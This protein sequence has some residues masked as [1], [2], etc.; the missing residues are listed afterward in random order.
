MS[1]ESSPIVANN[2]RQTCED[3]ALDPHLYRNVT[4]DEYENPAGNRDYGDSAYHLN[5]I[6]YDVS[7][8]HCE[9]QG[10]CRAVESSGGDKIQELNQAPLVKDDIDKFP[11]GEAMADFQK[12][13]LE[14]TLKSL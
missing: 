11:D 4:E 7:L 2:S 13:K 8:I 14:A 3:Y 6:R 5:R 10:N 9:T 12:R 1:Y